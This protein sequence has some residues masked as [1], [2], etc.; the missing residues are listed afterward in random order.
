MPKNYMIGNW[1]MN[2]S[3]SEINAFFNEIKLENNQNNFWIAP[4]S[5]HIATC[6]KQANE[7]GILIGSQNISDQDNGAFTGEI[8]GD[9]LMEIGA[10]FSLIGHSER[11]SLY[12]ESDSFIN[13]K[14]IKAIDKGIVPVVCCG[15][16]L[17]QRENAQT[18][19]T[20]LSQL[21]AALKNVEL[22]NFAEL[23]IAYEP[24]WAI[25]TGKTASPQQAGEVHSKIRALLIELYGDLGNELTILYGGSVKPSNIKELMEQDD[26]NGGL[27]GGASL[28]AESFN[29]LCA[30]I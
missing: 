17:E 19:T 13:S 3:L 5:L 11:R 18:F 27:V 12:G 2:Q 9:A 6:I 25:G 29:L 14:V 15:E 26:I 24:V 23:V 10:H 30:A 20:V 4:Q 1:K 7:A 8:S 22:N 21:K 16:T 28:K